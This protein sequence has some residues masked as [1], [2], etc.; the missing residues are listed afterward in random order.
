[1]TKYLVKVEYNQI[2]LLNF[3]SILIC[4]TTSYFL[5]FF[6][7]PIKKKEGR[8][9]TGFKTLFFMIDVKFTDF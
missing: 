7:Y 1:M 4:T 3:K 5:P 2:F 9:K 8:R 6:L